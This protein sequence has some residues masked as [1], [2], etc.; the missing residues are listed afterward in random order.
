MF[1]EI[2]IPAYTD[3]LVWKLAVWICKKARCPIIASEPVVY[4]RNQCDKIWTVLPFRY[5]YKKIEINQK[6]LLF[7][8]L[9]GTFLWW[10]HVWRLYVYCSQCSSNRFCY[11]CINNINITEIH[12]LPIRDFSVISHTDKCY[13]TMFY[14]WRTCI[15]SLWVL[16]WMNASILVYFYETFLFIMFGQVFMWKGDIFWLVKVKSLVPFC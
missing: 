9:V 6:D 13:L 1:E 14:A 16:Q 12:I 8:M 15:C 11:Y 3:L 7:I 5:T 2:K 4:L 10:L